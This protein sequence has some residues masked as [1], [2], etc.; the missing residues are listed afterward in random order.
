MGGPL[1]TPKICALLC[2][3]CL[4]WCVSSK[5]GELP[6]VVTTNLRNSLEFVTGG[7]DDDSTIWVK[8]G[9]KHALLMTLVETKL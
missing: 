8:S 3:G 5:N 4:A 6:E 1:E 9:R 7:D 2:Q